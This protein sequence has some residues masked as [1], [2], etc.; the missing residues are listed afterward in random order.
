MSL[1]G[2]LYGKMNSLIKM[3]WLLIFIT[4]DSLQ[5]L[6]LLVIIYVKSYLT[7]GGIVCFFVRGGGP[8]FFRPLLTIVKDCPPCE[9]EKNSPP[10]LTEWKKIWS[11][12]FD[13]M[14]KSVPPFWTGEK[15]LVPV[16]AFP[17]IFPTICH[18][19]KWNPACIYTDCTAIPRHFYFIVCVVWL[20]MNSLQMCRPFLH[21]FPGG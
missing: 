14:K 18:I 8:P 17:Q 11:G 19:A 7:K 13:F 12:P 20:G 4:W 5:Y 21:P 10:P 2:F 16:S 1:G 9:G 3:K 15:K 6:C